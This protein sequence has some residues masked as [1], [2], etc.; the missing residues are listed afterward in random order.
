MN[1]VRIGAVEYLNARPLVFGLEQDPRF[2][3]R[4]DLPSRCAELLHAGDIDLGL[5]PSIEFLRG[6][7]GPGSYRI[8]PRLAI[9]S[10]GPV[11]S[12]AIYTTRDMRDVRSIALDT[13][14]RTSVA[15][16]RVMCARVFGMNPSLEAHGPN[17]VEML[18]GAD[19]ALIIGD[20]ALFLDG[21]TIETAEG[22]TVDVEKVDLG[23]LWT[24]T[25]GLPF[26]YAFWAGRPGVVGADQ[27]RALLDTR[28][29]SCADPRAVASAYYPHDEA[30]QATAERYL[31]DNI[32]Y[33]LGAD[34]RAGLERFYQYAAELGLVPA[35]AVPL[36]FDGLN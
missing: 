7:A 14:S 27:M 22:R 9:G 31:R 16:T 11:A 6:G 25:T 5:I 35:P 28:D 15:L 4:F 33:D 34:E 2:L 36:Y 8:V 32:K 17:L 12:V 20:R 3:V 1:Q 24:R 19:A 13:S 30:R 21:G 23:D 26:V 10:R 18:A 29:A